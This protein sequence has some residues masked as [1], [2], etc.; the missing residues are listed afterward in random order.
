MIEAGIM[1]FVIGWLL[2]RWHRQRA[3]RRER[4]KFRHYILGGVRPW[5]GQR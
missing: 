4:Q 1:L 5:W 2:R 3:A